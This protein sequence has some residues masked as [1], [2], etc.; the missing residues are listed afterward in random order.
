M[1]NIDNIEKV[2]NSLNVYQEYIEQIDVSMNNENDYQSYEFLLDNASNVKTEISSF[3]QGLTV[4]APSDAD[5]VNLDA[6]YNQFYKDLKKSNDVNNQL[7]TLV[8]KYQ[9]TEAK[10]SNAKK[11]N[12]YFMLLVW[13]VIFLFIGVALFLSIIEDKKDMNIFSKSLLVLFSLVIFFYIVKNL[14]VYIER[15]IQ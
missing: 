1:S 12:T 8:S 7:K 5:I 14:K 11:T 15:N 9:A 2:D 10:L 4:N 6:S 3:L 13:I